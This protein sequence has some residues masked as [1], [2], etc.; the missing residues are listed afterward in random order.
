MRTPALPC[1]TSDHF[2]QPCAPAGCLFCAVFASACSSAPN[3]A[4]ARCATSWWWATAAPRSIWRTCWSAL[5]PRFCLWRPGSPG[6]WWHSRPGGLEAPGRRSC[7][8][9]AA[10]NFVSG[11][12]SPPSSP[13]WA[14]RSLQQSGRGR[15]LHPAVF[16]AAGVRQHA[17]QPPQRARNVQR[18]VI[19]AEGMAMGEPTPTGLYQRRPAQGL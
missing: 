4:T 18:V 7:A 2:Y 10:R 8:L 16:G 14:P 13:G 11:R 17:L 6:G 15:G 12:P 3:T 9:S 19:T 1:Y 5:P